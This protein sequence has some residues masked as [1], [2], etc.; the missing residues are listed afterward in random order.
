MPRL[1]TLLIALALFAFASVAAADEPIPYDA[2][3]AKALTDRN[4]TWLESVTKVAYRTAGR[5]DARWDADVETAFRVNL[6]RLYGPFWDRPVAAARF[7]AALEFAVENGCDDPLIRYLRLGSPLKQALTDDDETAAADFLAAARALGAS[8]YPAL[9]KA[10]AYLDAIVALRPG[11]DETGSCQNELIKALVELA[12]DKDPAARR[13]LIGLCEQTHQVG[14]RLLHR[15]AW[16][17][18]V[19][20]DVL[21]GLPKSDPVPHACAGTFL[22]RYAWDAR[23]G[24]VASTVTAESGKLFKERLTEAEKRLTKAW[25][26]DN[27]CAAASVQMVTVC[28]G[29]GHKRDTMETWF[30]RTVSADPLR[31]DVYDRKLNYL[32]PKWHGKAEDRVTFGQQVAKLGH[33]DTALPYCLLLAHRE[34]APAA[35]RARTSYFQS[36]EVWEDVGPVLEEIRKRQPNSP[37]GASLYLFYAWQCE[38]NA[39]EALKY[40]E[41]QKV[42]LSLGLFAGILEIDSAK[43]WAEGKAGTKD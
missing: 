26:L 36:P 2:K 20:K 38:R 23:G 28:M 30:R 29:L 18:R 14:A 3:K 11:S 8:K 5:R 35:G 22:V 25:E 39:S 43:T 37:L 41:A 32:A 42:P 19:E 7:K 33:W 12:K 40:V 6:D 31:F 17:D 24:G 34:A 4:R 16:F 9:W 27:E 21:A 10:Q 15:K 13:E 1:R